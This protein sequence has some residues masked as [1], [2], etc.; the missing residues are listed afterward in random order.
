MA[1]LGYN[2]KDKLGL[3]ILATNEKALRIGRHA[4]HGF[5]RTNKP[6]PVAYKWAVVIRTE[7]Q[8]KSNLQ[9]PPVYLSLFF[10]SRIDLEMSALDIFDDQHARLAIQPTAV[11][12]LPLFAY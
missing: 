8:L 9:H 5:T 6:S 10:R 4:P 12:R 7:R 2:V 1:S 3:A 11:Q